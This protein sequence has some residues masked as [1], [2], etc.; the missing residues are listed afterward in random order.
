METLSTIFVTLVTVCVL[1]GWGFWEGYWAAK[2]EA[3]S[4]EKKE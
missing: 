3:A 1:W 2:R 4:L